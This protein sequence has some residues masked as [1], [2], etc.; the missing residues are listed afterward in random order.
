MSRDPD[1]AP[2]LL[3]VF[4]HPDDESL[5]AGGL[6]AWCASLGGRVAVLCLTRGELRVPDGG[7]DVRA[8]ELAAAAA[9]L[10]VQDVRLRDF[11]DGYLTWEPG[12]A[13]EAEIQAA[14]D[15]V[16]PDLIVTFDADGLYWHPD[17][18]AVHERTTAV[19]TKLGAAAPALFYVSM[20]HGRLRGH[21]LGIDAD[22]F[23]ACAPT[24]THRLDVGRFASIKMAALRCHRTQVEGDP[25]DALSEAEAREALGLELYRRAEVGGAGDTFLD[26]IST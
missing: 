17:H 1:R 21:V 18:V 12:E 16:A 8:G 26:R 3:A 23:G 10:G 7:A 15:L 22:A 25:V 9:V 4:A 11:R 6:L 5:A 2:S 13:I 24:A 19:V 20:P 14:I